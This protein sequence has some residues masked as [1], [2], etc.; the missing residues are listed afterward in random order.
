[1][2]SNPYLVC[3][4][5]VLGMYTTGA[6]D[7]GGTAGGTTGAGGAGGTAGGTTGDGGAGEAGGPADDG[8]GTESDAE[9]KDVVHNPGDQVLYI[10]P[11][12]IDLGEELI[13]VEDE[14]QQIL[15]DYNKDHE[16]PKDSTWKPVSTLFTHPTNNKIIETTQHI[17]KGWGLFVPVDGNTPVLQALVH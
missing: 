5:P 9:S 10:N 17:V 7:A 15:E 14:C 8:Y 12:D 16:N 3:A 2:R 13:R 6:G 4:G 11:L 1:M